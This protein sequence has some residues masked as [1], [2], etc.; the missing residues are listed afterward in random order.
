VNTAVKE[1]PI[2]RAVRRQLTELIVKQLFRTKVVEDVLGEPITKHVGRESGLYQRLEQLMLKPE[3]RKEIM[4]ALAEGAKYLLI[5]AGEIDA[6]WLANKNN[7]PTR[8][9]DN[10]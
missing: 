8:K 9:S 6:N 10:Q 3:V 1:F 5:K 4:R 7:R 2:E